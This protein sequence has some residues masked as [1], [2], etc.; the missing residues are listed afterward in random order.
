M[1]EDNKRITLQYS[2]RLK[3]LPDEVGRLYQQAL[4]AVDEITLHNRT[5]EEILQPAVVKDIDELRQKLA[6][7]DMMLLDL[8]SIVGSYIEYEMSQVQQPERAPESEPE[9]EFN[10]ASFTNGVGDAADPS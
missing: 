9:S 7:T 2:I 6:V 1:N 5:G 10:P 8:Q 3:D 4:G